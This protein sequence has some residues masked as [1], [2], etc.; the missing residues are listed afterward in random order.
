[1]TDV[2]TVIMAGG[3]HGQTSGGGLAVMYDIMLL[4]CL[5]WDTISLL[6]AREQPESVGVLH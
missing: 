4:C 2:M 1:M 5:S 6:L 3:L